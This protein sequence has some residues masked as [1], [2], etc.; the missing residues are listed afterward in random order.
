MNTAENKNTAFN[1][2]LH[3]NFVEKQVEYWREKGY[4]VTLLHDE[5]IISPKK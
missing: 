5:I 2:G 4:D 3:S 1:Q